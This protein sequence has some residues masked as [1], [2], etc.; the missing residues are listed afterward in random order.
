MYF[1]WINGKHVYFGTFNTLKEAHEYRNFLIK[2]NW[3]LKYKKRTSRK[4]NLPKYIYQKPGK[5][6][7]IIQKTV[8][9]QQVHFGTYHS[10][11]E[12][13]HERDFY[14]SIDWDFDL[15]DLY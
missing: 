12:A 5:N 1:K 13:V 8:N 3:E 2:Q 10:L 9:Y 14:Q 15:L 7:F 11:E 4:Y 6:T